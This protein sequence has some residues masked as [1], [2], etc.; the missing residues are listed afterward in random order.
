MKA[1]SIWQPYAS[2]IT[3]GIKRYETRGWATKYRGP[4]LIC[5]AKKWDLERA[6]DCRRV[7]RILQ[8]VDWP[9]KTGVQSVLKEYASV[10][11][12]VDMKTMLG[13][14]V[15][16]VDL[17]D[18]QPMMDGGS[19]LENAV[20]YFGEGRFGWRCENPRAFV[21]PIPVVGKQGLWNPSRELIEAA[22][23]LKDGEVCRR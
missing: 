18:C 5:A 20:G 1:L 3:E 23:A 8:S 2:L 15:G 9:V 22:N 17:V 7:S 10:E 11:H 21:S 19:E 6:Q 4:L 12:L 14:A 13:V 16:V